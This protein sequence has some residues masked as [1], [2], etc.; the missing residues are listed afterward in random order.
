MKIAVLGAGYTG[1]ACAWHLL[2]AP[3]RPRGLEVTVFDEKGIGG[4]ASG[5]AAG[6]LHPYVGMTAKIN[7][8]GL[9]GLHATERLIEESSITLGRPV[10]LAK[11]LLRVALSGEQAKNFRRSANEN[12]DVLWWEPQECLTAVPCLST[13]I[14]G[15][16]YIRSGQAVSSLDYLQ[17][18]WKSCLLQNAAFSKL[19]IERLAQLSH[20]DRILVAAG[21]GI[22]EIEELIEMPITLVKGQLLELQ[23]PPGMEALPF[24][25]NSQA[26]VV[27]NPG[28]KTCIV[29]ATYERQYESSRPDMPIAKQEIL[30]KLSFL[31]KLQQAPVLGCRA[32]FRVSTP[33]HLPVVKQLNRRTWVLTGMGSKGLLY[34][35]LF[36]QEL[37]H[38]ILSS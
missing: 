24:P 33:N 22:L 21:P 9:E 18:L 8:R 25:V 5:I 34:H 19:P 10:A 15:G 30:A 23:W 7:W 17:G 27:M 14:H 6:L 28:N 37:A 31:P 26:Y 12:P 1:L 2:H 16:I 3:F 29:G 4:G 38:K 35:A 36:A 32:H 13:A 11:G 20:F